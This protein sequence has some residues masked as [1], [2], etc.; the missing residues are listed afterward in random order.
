MVNECKP[1][2]VSKA[3]FLFC[4]YTVAIILWAAFIFKL[5]WL[6]FVS[7]GILALS[8]ILK[9]QNAPLV[10]SYTNTINRFIKSENE[11]LDEVGMQFA[12]TLGSILNLICILLVYSV[13]TSIGWSFVAI[14][15]LAKT[16]GAMGFCTALKLYNC[17]KSGGCCNLLAKK[18]KLNQSDDR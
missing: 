16:A 8:A 17:L 2:S 15:A 13:N 4:K 9:I 3:A 11:I 18:T 5:K 12:H 1:V 14:V 6:L 10:W 7:F